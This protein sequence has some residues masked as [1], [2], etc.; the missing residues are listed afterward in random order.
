M[1][2]ACDICMTQICIPIM[3]FLCF[4]IFLFCFS[5]E[6]TRCL[7]RRWIPADFENF[8]F[9][10]PLMHILITCEK[11]FM[12]RQIDNVEGYHFLNI[13]IYLPFKCVQKKRNASANFFSFS[14]SLLFVLIDLKSHSPSLFGDRSPVYTSSVVL[15][16]V[17]ASN[18][19]F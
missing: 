14:L 5:N 18:W 4:R 6:A 15:I 8:D 11:K 7:C 13:L 17:L 3:S 9:R 1:D 12:L 2:I 16:L 19:N 10:Y